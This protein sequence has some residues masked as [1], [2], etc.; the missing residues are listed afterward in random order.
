MGGGVET[1]VARRIDLSPFVIH[2]ELVKAFGVTYQL[3]VAQKLAQRGLIPPREQIFREPHDHNA[4]RLPQ[5]WSH[6]IY[7]AD[8][9]TKDANG[10]WHRVL[11]SF[12]NEGKQNSSG[13]TH[14]VE[15][16]RYIVVR[17]KG[18]VGLLLNHTEEVPLLDEFVVEPGVWHKVRKNGG[19]VL[20]I[21]DMEDAKPGTE[22]L[23]HD[24]GET[25]V[26]T[27]GA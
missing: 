11:V 4:N 8:Y 12:Y 15:R 2:E 14:H 27:L 22:H 3:D 18:E 6:G 20:L 25:L 24:H 26:Y 17:R 1:G 10:V 7:I 16:E 21:I 19:P 13:H 9:Y 5:H 23:Q